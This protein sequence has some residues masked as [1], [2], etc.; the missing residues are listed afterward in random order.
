MDTLTH[1]LL[2]V[3]VAALP[4]PR[5]LARRRPAPASAAVLVSVLAAELP[6]LDYLL[7]AEDAVLHALSAHRGYS[8]CLLAV[9]LVALVATLATKLVFR[10]PSFAVLYARA[11]L[12]VPLA[13][14]LPD[15]WTGWGTRLLLPLSER[16]LALDWTMVVDPVLTAPLLLAAVFAALRPQRWRR[17]MAA[18]AAVSALYL[19]LRVGLAAHLEA[20]VARAYP[21]AESVHVFPAPLSVTRLRY[22]AQGRTEYAAGSVALGREPREA[23]RH[24]ITAIGSLDARLRGVATVREALGWARFPLLSTAP[25]AGGTTRVRIADLRYHFDGSPT[26]SVVVEVDARGR[27]RS[28][29]LDRGGTPQQLLERLRTKGNSEGSRPRPGP[30]L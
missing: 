28:A 21:A 25:L 16:R 14:L 10:R 19:G 26:L 12:A 3:A 11:L 17:A 20:Q 9:P 29:E 4:L 13:H 15:L 24:G 2:G 22:V 23:A 30:L 18:G 27:A 6:D 1:G 8:H 5:Q 7:P